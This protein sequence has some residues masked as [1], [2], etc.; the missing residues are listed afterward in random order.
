MDIIWHFF[1]LNFM[2][3]ALLHRSRESKSL[4]RASQSALERMGRYM[5]QSS[6]NSLICDL[7][8]WMNEWRPNRSS[9][10]FT[11]SISPAADSDVL[12]S[13][14][15]HRQNPTVKASRLTNAKY[16]LIILWAD[17]PA[18]PNDDSIVNQ[19][20]ESKSSHIC[21]ELCNLLSQKWSITK[22]SI[23]IIV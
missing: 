11:L 4:C 20:A 8:E 19:V 13:Y 1:V 14:S 7:N 10:I 18:P 6:A 5:R 12:L 3:H 22:M 23:S 2:P 9:F 15:M 16:E 21:L 17:I